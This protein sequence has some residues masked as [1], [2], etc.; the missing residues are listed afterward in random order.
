MAFYNGKL[1][2]PGEVQLFLLMACVAA[3]EWQHLVSSSCCSQCAKTSLPGQDSIEFGVDICLYLSQLNCC[4]PNES[5]FPVQ[6]QLNQ[7]KYMYFS[8]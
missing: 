1:L 2:L 6:G 5:S 8:E 7:I 4:D 3:A